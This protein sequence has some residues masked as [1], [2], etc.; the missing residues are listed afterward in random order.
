M[1]GINEVQI[2]E[3]RT[4]FKSDK[5]A[6]VAQNAVTRA[7]FPEIAL[8]HE[9]LQ[10]TC[11]NFSTKLDDWSATNQ[12]SSGRCWLFAML[13]LF[14]KGAIQK[15]NVK[16][17]EFSQSFTF[18]YDKLERS[19]HFLEAIIDTVDQ[20]V[21]DRTVAHL[22]GDPIGD[23]GQWD[24]GVNLVR[25]YGAV[26]KSV[27]AETVSSSASRFMNV[28]LKSLLR[29]T[30]CELRA[31]S[32]DKRA[33]VKAERMRDIWRILCIHL[34]TPPERFEW[35]WTDKSG[36]AHDRGFMTPKEFAKE[37]ITEDFEDYVCLVH[38]P[39]NPYFQTYSVDKLQNVADG[40]RV[41]YLNIPVKEMQKITQAMLGEDKCVWMGCDVGKA[42]YRKA[43]I[44]DL[45][46]Y[47]IADLYGVRAYEMDKACRL[48]HRQTLM[49]HAMLFTGM[50]VV[51]ADAK[52]GDTDEFPPGTV[53]RWRVENSWGET[54]GSKGFYTMN[55]NWFAEHVSL[56]LY[57]YSVY[58]SSCS[59]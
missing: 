56:F 26:P 6:R 44:W 49:T 30:A 33:E 19:N 46:I 9:V 10:K 42:F 35:Q 38:D 40:P 21:D 22:L 39:R 23:G 24:M 2:N 32:T 34:G 5:C 54:N 43:G 14:R 57:I 31:A 59:I 48:Q 11:S 29:T 1:K 17:F 12:A 15:L 58:V 37:Y 45:G 4:Q 52:D 47:E 41:R 50:D 18:F 20:D 7:T 53:R 36:K 3:W 8:C 51:G 16:D 55:A 25:K 27:F 13:N 28:Q